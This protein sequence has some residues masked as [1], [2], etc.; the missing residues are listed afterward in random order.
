MRKAS[1]W[2]AV[3]SIVYA[4]IP[5][6]SMVLAGVIASIFGCPLDESGTSVCVTPVGDIGELLS[7]MGVFGWF[8]FFT[9]PT[10]L[11]GLIVA[12]ILFG[13]SF[14]PKKQK[15]SDITLVN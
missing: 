3:I 4:I 8:V 11:V 15:E 14:I 7:F 9:V 5:I 2:I 10:G 13:V 1:I 6:L 12:L